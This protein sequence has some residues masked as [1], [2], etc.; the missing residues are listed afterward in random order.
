[1]RADRE[2]N[3]RFT[4]RCSL[5]GETIP[6][7]TRA[8][9]NPAARNV[10]HI[11]CP[12]VGTGVPGASAMRE[13]DR[14]TARDAAKIAAR[15]AAVTAKFGDG[16]L[17]RI[18]SR[19]AVDDRPPRTTSIWKQGAIGERLVAARLDS[20]SEVS[21]V[22]LH[23]RRIPGTRANIDHIAITPWG[24]WVIDTKRYLAKRPKLVVSGG[25]LRPRKEDLK[26]GAH[27]ASKLVEGVAWQIERVRSSLDADVPVRGA[28]CFVDADWPLIGGDFTVRGIRVCWPGRLAKVLLQTEPPTLDVWAIT[29][30]LATRFVP[31]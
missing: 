16:F 1:M 15:K 23:D 10:R 14:R 2:M 29:R 3:L 18:A 6:K 4:G 13:Y 28:L 25:I 17:G 30:V 5:C 19:I 26:V 21:V 9:Y 8:I 27:L 12:T 20:L 7:G 11:A 31:A 24:V 22:A